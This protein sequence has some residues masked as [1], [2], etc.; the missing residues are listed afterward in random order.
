MSPRAQRQQ[1]LHRQVSDWFAERIAAQDEGFRPGDQLPPI[2]ETA[3]NWGVGFQVAQRAYELLQSA[4]LVE[5]Q[6]RKGT[7]VSQPRNVLG[8]LQRLRSPRVLT[9]EHIE[10]TAAELIPAPGY[11]IPI[12]GLDANGAG[13]AVIRREWVTSDS[14]GPFMLNVS[15]TP[16]RFAEAA[17][18]LLEQV[19]LPDGLSAAQLAAQR[20]RLVPDWGRASREARMVKTDGREDRLLGAGAHCLAEVYVWGSGDTVLEY[21]E[22]IVREGRVIESDM[23]P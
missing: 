12:L 8:P 2:R 9:A 16:A 4:R 20:A 19:P 3:E 21:G 7:F 18:E 23:E 22:F 6:G 11:V 13:R 1:P 17:H 15:W 10:V 5:S 14:A